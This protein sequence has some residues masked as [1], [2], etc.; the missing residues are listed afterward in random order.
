MKYPILAP[1][2]ETPTVTGTVG[3]ME[4]GWGSKPRYHDGDQIGANYSTS[5][6]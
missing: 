1:K 5:E 2:K 3:A 6:R 4:E